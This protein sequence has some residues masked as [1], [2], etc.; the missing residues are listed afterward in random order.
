[1]YNWARVQGYTFVCTAPP[2]RLLGSGRPSVRSAGPPW[3]TAV[4]AVA[5]S[6][7]FGSILGHFWCL[8]GYFVVILM[9]CW[10]LFS[11]FGVGAGIR[12]I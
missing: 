7:G 1:M 12:E 5:P 8:L 2:W 11:D 3:L 9:R 10:Y 6:R 4:R